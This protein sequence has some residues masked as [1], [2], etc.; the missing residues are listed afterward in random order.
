MHPVPRD[1]LDAFAFVVLHQ[2][3][4]RVEQLRPHCV[5][6]DLHTTHNNTRRISLD[7][8]TEDVEEQ[9]RRC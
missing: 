8:N 5:P 3:C 9:R 6:V 2:L 7:D 4:Q 1:L